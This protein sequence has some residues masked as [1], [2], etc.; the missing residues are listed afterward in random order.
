M[1]FDPGIVGMPGREELIL[2]GEV[3]VTKATNKIPERSGDIEG[4]QQVIFIFQDQW[5]LLF[6]TKHPRR[7]L[8][9]LD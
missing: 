1:G 8:R 3:E 9:Q 6:G 2:T 5:L 4:I 7:Q